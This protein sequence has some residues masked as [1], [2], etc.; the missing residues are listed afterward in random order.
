M[1]SNKCSFNI[2]L[3]NNSSILSNKYANRCQINAVLQALTSMKDLNL[4]FI[5]NANIFMTDNYNVKLAKQ[6]LIFIIEKY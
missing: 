1:N 4:Y 2:N 3:K 6:Y 5:N